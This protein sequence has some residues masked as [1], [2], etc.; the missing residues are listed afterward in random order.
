MGKRKELRDFSQL[1]AV[2]GI[3]VAGQAYI[4]LAFI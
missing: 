3:L 4:W 2:R 1:F